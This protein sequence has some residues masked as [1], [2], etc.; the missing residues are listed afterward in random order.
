MKLTE[1]TFNRIIGNIP[2][3]TWYGSRRSEVK[4]I[5]TGSCL[6]CA[7]GFMDD[8]DDVDII[9]A[10]SDSSFWSELLDLHNISLSN[11]EY[12]NIKIESNGY[13]YN[14]IRDDSYFTKSEATKI[15]IDGEIYL[16]SL[17]HA[18]SAK[19]NL[20]RDKDIAH[21]SIINS[22]LKTLLNL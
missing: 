15:T 22:R 19:K 9:V 14:I 16:D 7:Y 13:V 18:L 11:E 20:N 6:L 3:S 21:F 2:I 5:L 17:Y 8:F 10:N 12:S 1:D 4:L